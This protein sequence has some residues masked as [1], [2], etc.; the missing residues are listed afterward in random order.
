MPLGVCVQ[1]LWIG[2]C[3]L[4]NGTCSG[5][6]GLWCAEPGAAGSEVSS[7]PAGHLAPLPLPH[8]GGGV[9]VVV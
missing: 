6:G 1:L 9:G 4:R 2:W 7:A 5:P 8:S 3:I